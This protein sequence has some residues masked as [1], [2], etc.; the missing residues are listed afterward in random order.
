MKKSSV[1]LAAFILIL[2]C[3]NNN[4]DKANSTD[5][6]VENS[7]APEVKEVV[8]PIEEVVIQNQTWALKN[9]D[10][11]HFQ[12]GDEIPIYTNFDDFS[13]AGNNE[14]PAMCYYD[15]DSDKGIIYGAFYNWYALNDSR[16]IAPSGWRVPTKNDWELLVSNL[17]GEVEAVEK[18]KSKKMCLIEHFHLNKYFP[19]Y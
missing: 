15:F 13:M 8:K 10:V 12:N 18:I 5:V 14:E 4:S 1:L 9:L 11:T 16:E 2:S 7:S 17:G 19:F 3:K 6:V